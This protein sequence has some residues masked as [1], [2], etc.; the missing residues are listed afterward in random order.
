[1]ELRKRQEQQIA[2]CMTQRGF[3]YVVPADEALGGY[4]IQ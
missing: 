1:M 2:Q 3:E 4:G